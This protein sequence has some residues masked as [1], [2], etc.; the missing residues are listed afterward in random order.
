VAA[1][2]LLVVAVDV[3]QAPNDKQQCDSAWKKDPV[4]GVIGVQKGPL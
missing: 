3:V 2:S 4:G 1:D